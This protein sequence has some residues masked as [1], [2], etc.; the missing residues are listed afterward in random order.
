MPETRRAMID[1]GRLFGVPAYRW[2]P[3]RA[4]LEVEYWIAA[5][6][7]DAVPTSWESFAPGNPQ[8]A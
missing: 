3:A 7:A 6:T 5:R 2:L 4:T 8:S 1:R